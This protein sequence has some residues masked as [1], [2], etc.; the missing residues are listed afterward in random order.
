MDIKVRTVFDL[1]TSYT[2]ASSTTRENILS[3]LEEIAMTGD[4]IIDILNIYN[5]RHNNSSNDCSW[6]YIGMYDK[7]IDVKIEKITRLTSEALTSK[8]NM[9][10]GNAELQLKEIT[11]TGKDFVYV[12]AGL[13]DVNHEEDDIKERLSSG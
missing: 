12:L 7:F 2:E 3:R 9:V 6:P 4:E 1:L 8:S 11:L 10:G 13:Y 5:Q